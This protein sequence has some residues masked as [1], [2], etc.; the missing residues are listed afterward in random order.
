MDAV[1]PGTS[2]SA[3]EFPVRLELVALRLRFLELER[4]LP[5]KLRPDAFDRNGLNTRRPNR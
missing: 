1:V 3:G 5:G 4:E 2:R